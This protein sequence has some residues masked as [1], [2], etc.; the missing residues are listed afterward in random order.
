MRRILPPVGE[1]TEHPSLQNIIGPKYHAIDASV[2]STQSGIN[3]G[4]EDD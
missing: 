3:A 1:R 2:S 4:E